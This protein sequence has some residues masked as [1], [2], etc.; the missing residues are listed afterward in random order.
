MIT[1]FTASFPFPRLQQR[2]SEILS[3]M[4]NNKTEFEPN[5]SGCLND[6]TVRMRSKI[7]DDGDF[8]VVLS[9]GIRC[10]S[11][12]IIDFLNID[13]PTYVLS[14]LMGQ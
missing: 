13:F 6:V 1:S 5:K 4:L 11:G 10:V 2:F 9:F 12:V 14:S 3:H 8:N 7:S